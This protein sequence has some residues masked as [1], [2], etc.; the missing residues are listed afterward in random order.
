MIIP[1]QWVRVISSSLSRP[2]EIVP[3]PTPFWPCSSSSRRR[4]F[5]G[6]TVQKEKYKNYDTV[7]LYSHEIEYCSLFLGRKLNPMTKINQNLTN[8]WWR[9]R[10][11]HSF[12]GAHYR[13]IYLFQTPT[14]LAFTIQNKWM[15]FFSQAL[16]TNDW[17][18]AKYFHLFDIIKYHTQ[19]RS[20]LAIF[21]ADF[22][23]CH[24][25]IVYE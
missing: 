5:R 14:K 21:F 3:S 20:R 9:I 6:T 15:V 7:Q 4:K 1:V 2:H 18:D 16:N 23:K 25:Y 12:T 24:H 22:D 19:A 17:F 10:H 13:K 11:D 8:A